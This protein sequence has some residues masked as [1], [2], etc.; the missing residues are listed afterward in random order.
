M[1]CGF[2]DG[3]RPLARGVH[4]RQAPQ[5]AAEVEPEAAVRRKGKTPPTAGWDIASMAP[6][7]KGQR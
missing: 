4:G 7:M 3:G 5:Q 2:W 1:G 6:R